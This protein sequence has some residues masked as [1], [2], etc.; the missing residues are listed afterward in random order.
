MRVSSA[1]GFGTA[2][3]RIAV[4]R[5]VINTALYDMYFMIRVP[6]AILH[7]TALLMLDKGSAGGLFSVLTV[8]DRFT[9]QY[10]HDHACAH[11]LH[12]RDTCTLYF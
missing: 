5:W 4:G 9:Y 3:E 7:G 6:V 8:I 11:T 2:L 1:S 12:T 10:Y